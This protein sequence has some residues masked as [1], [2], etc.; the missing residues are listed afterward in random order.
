MLKD[1]TRIPMSRSQNLRVFE[2]A[3]E[4]AGGSNS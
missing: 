2:L 3:G 1:G 4:D